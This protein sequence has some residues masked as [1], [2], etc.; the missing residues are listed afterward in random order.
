[1]PLTIRPKSHILDAI[2]SS[3]LA[4]DVVTDINPIGVLRQACEGVASTQADLE[5]DLYVLSRTFYIT[6]AEG[7]DLDIQ[8][9][10]GSVSTVQAV[11]AGTATLAPAIGCFAC[12]RRP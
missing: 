2:L 6:T 7:I 4:G 5:Y 12:R 3:V 1:M 8:E 11:A 9:G 10:R